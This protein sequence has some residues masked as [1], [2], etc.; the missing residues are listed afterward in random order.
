MNIISSLQT[1]SN[2]RSPLL[3]LPLHNIYYLSRWCLTAVATIAIAAL[4]PAVVPTTAAAALAVVVAVTTFTTTSNATATIVFT[5]VA[6]N[7]VVC[8]TF[9]AAI[10]PFVLALILLLI[11][12]LEPLLRLPRVIETGTLQTTEVSPL[13]WG[14]PHRVIRA[15]GRWGAKG[16]WMSPLARELWVTEILRRWS[17]RTLPLLALGFL[18][19]LASSFSCHQGF[20]EKKRK[21]W[22]RIS[23]TWV[24]K[25]VAH[26][27]PI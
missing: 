1:D 8:S 24:N 13:P 15:D 20:L 14:Q 27:W 17:Q 5:T 3:L 10:I 12:L 9:I 25:F 22:E 2:K 16:R 23:K 4:R 19:A 6:A 26:G 18:S 7:L 11:L 21:D